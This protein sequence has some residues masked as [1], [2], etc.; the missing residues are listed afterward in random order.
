MS[1]NFNISL[2][3]SEPERIEQV[4]LSRLSV[5]RLL[6]GKLMLTS[7]IRKQS[8]YEDHVLPFCTCMYSKFLL[9]LDPTIKVL[10]VMEYDL[11]RNLLYILMGDVKLFLKESGST[12]SLQL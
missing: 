5:T 3:P 9:K 4:K 12:S 6:K 8:R 11:K 7:G 2:F 10:P 1:A